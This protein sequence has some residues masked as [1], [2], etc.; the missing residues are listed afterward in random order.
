MGV[1]GNR[2]TGISI[3]FPEL[4]R[5]LSARDVVQ[6]LPMREAVAAMKEAFRQISV[7]EVV[8]PARTH[9]ETAQ[10]RGV[11][12]PLILGGRI[13]GQPQPDTP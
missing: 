3:A 9:I 4:L 11:L 1:D 2:K 8:A 10:P 5:F 6:A 13:H 7:G 12:H